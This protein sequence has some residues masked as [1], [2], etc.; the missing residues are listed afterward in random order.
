MNNKQKWILMITLTIMITVVI[1]DEVSA[2]E[3][4]TIYVNG[5]SGNDS[6]DGL[7]WETA[8]SSIKNATGTVNSNGT[9][10]IANGT[11]TGINNTNITINK[12]I[13]I[14]GQSKK[15]TI[16]DALGKTGIFIINSG[17]TISIRNLTLQNGK[18]EN[19][20]GAI[21]NRGS[22]ITVT[23]CIFKGN[24]AKDGGAIANHHGVLYV[25]K[26]TFQEN[27][28]EFGGAI[29][30]QWVSILNI[31][32][33]NF[34]GNSASVDGGALYNDNSCTIVYT[35]FE[36]N[37]ALREGGAI[38]NW[39]RN[40]NLKI[41]HS[42]FTENNATQ[43]GAIS[44]KWDCILLNVENSTFTGNNATVD[45]GAIYNIGG[46]NFLTIKNCEFI[47]NLAQDDGGAIY[48]SDNLNINETNFTHN[49][50]NGSGGAICILA[51][52]PYEDNLINKC[53]FLNN[54]AVG[55]GAI[56]NQWDSLLIVTESIFQ[57]NNAGWGGALSNRGNCTVNGCEF[58]RNYVKNFSGAS[59]GAIYTEGIC[60]VTKSK[61]NF[62][63]SIDEGGAISNWF[64]TCIITESSFTYNIAN[65]KAANTSDSYPHGN[66]G[67]IFNSG[68]HG[69]CLPHIS[70]PTSHPSG[71]LYVA[72]CNFHGNIASGD[73]PQAVDD[74]YTA[75]EDTKLSDNVSV[76]DYLPGN[77]GAI[78]NEGIANINN[79]NFTDNSAS[80]HGGAIQD[81]GTAYINNCTFKDNIE[82]YVYIWKLE[83]TPNHGNITFQ[84][85]G[86]FIY[87]PYANWN[88]I[89]SFTYTI[90]DGNGGFATAMVTITVN[91]VNDA[92]T[93]N[94]I[95]PNDGVD[96]DGVDIKTENVN[97][98]AKSEDIDDLD[99]PLTG[100]A[101]AGVSLW[102]SLT[103]KSPPSPIGGLNWLII[104]VLL[105]VSVL[106]TIGLM[107]RRTKE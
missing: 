105:L 51:R 44:N 70:P 20:G 49:S 104:M 4:D 67:A 59:G 32:H 38:L 18:S 84:K 79:C 77:G 26:S 48:S 24:S 74:N 10:N 47:N 88:G 68:P 13:E 9:I 25:Y 75:D 92:P 2:A 46:A 36:N 27:N 83:N 54:S 29:V 7:S 85:D 31:A 60:T 15:G 101:I 3:G 76:N 103:T 82:Q 23:D 22:V 65:A 11:Y 21:Y 72:D 61:F 97:T 100:L 42:N 95:N 45:G 94:I 57:E 73:Y 55:G 62:N 69:H 63:K 80:G 86:T 91:P 12:S 107:S 30:N 17:Y 16:I 43:G 93:D 64:G 1:S 53:Q 98:I 41:S 40:A 89:D 8:K 99:A 5:S 66:A 102:P 56:S 52:G 35:T 106:L 81:Y 78:Y 33:C 87:I 19:Y 28:A 58:I 39:R 90:S 6:N 71:T 37:Y 50:A 14:V 96:N 34:N